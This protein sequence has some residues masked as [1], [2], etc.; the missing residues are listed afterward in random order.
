[1]FEW[2][3]ELIVKA[4]QYENHGHNEKAF[5]MFSSVV[6]RV[7][8]LLV[9]GVL[10]PDQQKKCYIEAL[11][12][13][14]WLKIH[15]LELNEALTYAQKAHN[16]EKQLYSTHDYQALALSTLGVVYQ[17]SKRFS[18]AIDIFSELISIA[19]TRKDTKKNIVGLLDRAV[20]YKM[21]HQYHAALEDYLLVQTL[22][23]QNSD[24]KSED[25]ECGLLANI[26][27]VYATLHDYDTAL[28]FMHRA[29]ALAKNLSDKRAYSQI[30]GNMGRIY[31]LE[32]YDNYNPAKA[33]E[34]LRE[35]YYLNLQNDWDLLN[36]SVCKNLALLLDGINSDEAQHFREYYQ[37]LLEKSED[38]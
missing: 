27:T 30:V 32:S 4:Q 7:E 22:L 26:G 2:C 34:L 9:D 35:A 16:A 36:I 31:S 29:L 8:L 1:M 25:L 37:A 13:I 23:K 14:A 3:S 33:E 5:D 21:L 38:K 19:Q 18:D 10:L 15:S 24:A 6:S 17:R 12:K 20:T 28:H 11:T